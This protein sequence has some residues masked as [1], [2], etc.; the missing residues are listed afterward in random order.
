MIFEKSGYILADFGFWRKLEWVFGDDLNFGGKV[1]LEFFVD[2]FLGVV[3]EVEDFV[4][5]GAAF[6]D[7]EV[8]V[9]FGDL[10]VADFEAFEAG[11]VE[12]DAGGF[13]G[14]GVFEEGAGGENAEGLFLEAVLAKR[15]DSSSLGFFVL[16]SCDAEFGG[17]DDFVCAFEVAV[18]VVEVEVLRGHL[19]NA[20]YCV[21][22]VTSSSSYKAIRLRQRFLVSLYG[23]VFQMSLVVSSRI[24]DFGADEAVFGFEAAAAG[25]AVDGATDGAGEADPRFEAGEVV[26]E[27]LAD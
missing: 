14:E 25:V 5:G 18:A 26:G 17:E 22:C 4:C 8:G 12:E 19:K 7:K 24:E 1:D 3:H 20:P 27:H 21:N 2:G 15:G 11:L 23:I 16:A 9:F 6:V 13:F 10:G